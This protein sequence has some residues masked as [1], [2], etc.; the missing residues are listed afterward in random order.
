M[1]ARWDEVVTPNKNS[2]PRAQGVLFDLYYVIIQSH[3]KNEST[4]P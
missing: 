4:L 2:T 3:V 1:T